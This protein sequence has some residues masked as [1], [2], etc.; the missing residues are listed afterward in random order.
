VFGNAEPVRRYGAANYNAKLTAAQ[1]QE[2][3]A[4]RAAG[5]PF[6]ALAARYGVAI[7]TLYVAVQGRTWSHPSAGVYASAA[8]VTDVR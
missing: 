5:H 7:S 1:V 4:L 2:A 3:R 6:R 8:G